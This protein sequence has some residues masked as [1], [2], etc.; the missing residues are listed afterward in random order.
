MIELSSMNALAWPWI[1]LTAIAP[2]PLAARLPFN[3]A[4]TAMA[5]AVDVASM[6]ALSSAEI[7]TV[8]L[9]A[10]TSSASRM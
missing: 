5:V 6:A 4:A 10:V 2:P 8:P 3:L 9:V 7:H 1:K